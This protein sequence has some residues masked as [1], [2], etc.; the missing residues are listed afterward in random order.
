MNDFVDPKLKQVSEEADR[1]R[2]KSHRSSAEEKE[3]ERL[4]DL[5]LELKDFRDEL[6]RVA[7]FWKPNLNDGV[8]ITAAPLWK[9]FRHRQWKNR[10]KE[11][12]EKLEAG[13]YDWAH[14]ALSIW[15]ERVVRACQ[16][17]RSYAIAHDLE[18]QLWHEVE[19]EKVGRGGRVTTTTE[20]QPRDLS[21]DELNQI[22]AE[23]KAR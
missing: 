16:K 12:W 15:P 22:I 11:T 13:E 7:K 9:L 10:L 23:V 3:L 1:L 18:D 5:E 14:L 8:Q 19:V 4:T 2:G 6:L 20:W 17:D 21:E